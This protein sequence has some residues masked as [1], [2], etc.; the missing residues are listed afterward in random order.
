[1]PTPKPHLRFR[2]FAIRAG[3]V[4]GFRRP[5][6]IPR[7]LPSG[8]LPCAYQGRRLGLQIFPNACQAFPNFPLVSPNISKDS[9]GRFEGFQGV[10]GRASPIFESP[11]FFAASRAEIARKNP[12]QR[13]EA[14]PVRSDKPNSH[15][16]K[17][18]DCWQ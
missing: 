4:R 2:E 7:A 11:N 13:R 14:M 12:F 6:P 10:T 15:S 1:L 8:D 17:Y 18:S 16:S 9:F 3:Y 5:V